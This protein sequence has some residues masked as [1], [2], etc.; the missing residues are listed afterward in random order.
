MHDLFLVFRQHHHHRTLAIGAQAVAF[1]GDELGGF[2]EYAGRGQPVTQ[3]P[4]Q[5]DRRPGF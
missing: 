3:R 2:R 4:Q 5:R 1:V